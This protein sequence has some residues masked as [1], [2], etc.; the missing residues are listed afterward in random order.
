MPILDLTRCAAL[1]MSISD[2]VKQKTL[3]AP[4]NFQNYIELQKQTIT[5]YPYT[6]C[7]PSYEHLGLGRQF[8]IAILLILYIPVFIYRY[9]KY[10]FLFTDNTRAGPALGALAPKSGTP[11]R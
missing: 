2:P 3:C 7:L 9:F 1:L 5:E 6:Q 8:M 11:A 4:E 10:R